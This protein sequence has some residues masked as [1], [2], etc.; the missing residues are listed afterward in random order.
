M[1]SAIKH[2]V[3][4]MYKLWHCLILECSYSESQGHSKEL[5][6]LVLWLCFMMYHTP[7]TPYSV[8]YLHVGTESILHA[9]VSILLVWRKMKCL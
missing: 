7:H 6:P 4:I 9:E 5:R 2:Q 3:A 1:S 8:V